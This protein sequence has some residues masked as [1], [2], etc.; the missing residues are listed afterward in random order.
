MKAA[1]INAYGGQEVVTI[2]NDAVRPTI[3]G[4]QVLVEVHSAAVNPFDITVRE[5]LVRHKKE[6]NFPATLGGD[7]AGVVVELGGDVKDFNLGQEV[8]GRAGALSGNGSFAE[9]APVKVGDLAIKSPKTSFDEAAALPLAGASALM[10]L[11]E[12][13]KLQAGQKILIH[14][15]AGGIGAFAVQIAKN[16]GAYVATTVSNQDIEFAK[17]LGADIVIDYQSQDFETLIKD[18]DAVFDTTAGSQTAAKSY[19]VLRKG[20]IMVSMIAKPDTALQKQ[21]GVTAI[22]QF[23]RVTSDHLKQLAELVDSGVIK[24]NID[25]VFPLNQTAEAMEYLKTAH[26]HGKVVIR[27]KN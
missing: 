11:N 9:Y 25:K 3:A 5:G 2:N 24:V 21:Y 10:A 26:T 16:L 7:L 14:G 15:G 18:Y 13:L 6:L 20:G 12:H 22:A 17:S 8:F 4:D 1:Q 19:K 27:I 23:T